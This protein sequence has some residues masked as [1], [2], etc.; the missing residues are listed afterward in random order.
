MLEGGH[1]WWWPDSVDFPLP[2]GE[3]SLLGR[4]F[5]A[6]TGL[7]VRLKFI[8]RAVRARELTLLR[9]IDRF[10][11]KSPKCD[12]HVFG[13]EGYQNQKFPTPPIHTRVRGAGPETVCACV[14][15]RGQLFQRQE[16]GRS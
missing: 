4:R 12:F 7:G 5:L 14:G 2:T 16:S 11:G 8:V 15:G 9:R 10:E 1:W 3:L 6:W 13:Y